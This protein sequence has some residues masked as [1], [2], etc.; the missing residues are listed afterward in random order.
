MITSLFQIL[1][2]NIDNILVYKLISG[3]SGALDPHSEGYLNYFNFLIL[4]DK[5]RR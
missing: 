3:C 4:V 2:L 1:L 5:P